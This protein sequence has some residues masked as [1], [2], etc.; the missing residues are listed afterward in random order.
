MKHSTPTMLHGIFL[1]AI[2]L[3]LN[4]SSNAQLITESFSY[5]NTDSTITNL[6]TNW[7]AHSGVGSNQVKYFNAGLS[8]PKGYPNA[9][10]GA[11]NFTSGTGSR[12]DINR[13]FAAQSSGSLYAAS[14]VQINSGGAE[15]FFHFNIVSFFARVIATNSSGNLRFGISKNG[16]ASAAST[17]F[18]FG[19]TYLM[20]VKYEFIAGSQ[21]DKVSLWILDEPSV[22]ESLASTPLAT[23]SIGNDASSLLAVC[24]R[25]SSTNVSGT[26]DEIRVATT[27][28]EAVGNTIWDGSSWSL[29]TPNANS[30]VQL[31]SSYSLSAPM[32]CNSILLN[33]ACDLSIGPNQLSIYG[34]ISGEGKIIGS[35]V[36]DILI[37]G[38]ADTL[39]LK[40]GYE[41]LRNLTLNSG[42]KLVLGTKTNLCSGSSAGTLTL[43]SLSTLITQGNLVLQSDSLGTARIA[44]VSNTAT[45]D[46]AITQERF[47]PARRAYRFLA[48]AVTTSDGISQNW[49]SNT[50]ITGTGIGFD[51]TASNASSLFTLNSQ[52]QNW[53]AITNTHTQNLEQG[54]GYRILIRGDRSIDLSDNA[55]TANNCI[56][57]AKGTHTPGDKLINTSST[58]ALSDSIGGYSLIGN[59]FPSA[60]DWNSINRNN[61][62]STY[63]TWRAQG[64]ANGKGTYVN[65][66]A[67]GQVS[68]DGNINSTIGSGSAF[69]VQ[70]IGSNPSLTIEETDKVSNAQGSQ[71][72]GKT[73]SGELRLTLT[74]WDSSYLD[75]LLIYENPNAK[76]TTEEYDSKK[77]INPGISFYSLSEDESKLSIQGISNWESLTLIPIGW[78][79][80]EK[81]KYRLHFSS[82]LSANIPVYFIDQFTKRSFLLKSEMDYDFEVNEETESA[83]SN[84]F[85]L[86]KENTSG[87][88]KSNFGLN[89]HVFPNP[90]YD[91]ISIQNPIP[92]M[93]N[94]HY[95]ILDIQGNLVQTGLLD[96]SLKIN[97]SPLAPGVYFLEFHQGQQQ[98]T[99]KII[100]L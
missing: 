84:R 61:I 63:Y 52:T 17:N 33:N 4:L 1:L 80:Q 37:A 3:L 36:S 25:Q 93:E 81:K 42:S 6:T 100:H 16:V 99:K 62:A 34:K 44:A 57:S 11:I 71:I 72:L 59:P 2:C 10:G 87:L 94:I 26:I 43:N 27:W 56:L 74:D 5:G 46:G 13:T 21:N 50:H 51:L 14:L 15:Y 66:N 92:T 77:W 69:M 64:G 35:N 41:T 24:I 8:S 32:A 91:E 18:T 89:L 70:T 75:A 78:E 31:T 73:K 79:K 39:K 83:A 85:Y 23:D 55:A 28:E 30:N 48:S 20:V 7:E 47:I 12:E 38:I 40:T 58:S 90:C 54:I 98:L 49:Q 95:K 96:Q 76:N 22:S 9:S 88:V 60:I 68:S 82:S 29:G 65:Y 19:K 97:T 86:S 67:S 53:E 45:I